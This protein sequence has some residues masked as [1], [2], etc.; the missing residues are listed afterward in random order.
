MGVTVTSE[1]RLYIT[2]KALSGVY[3]ATYFRFQKFTITDGVDEASYTSNGG[4]LIIGRQWI[5]TSGFALA[6]FM[7]AGM[8][9]GNVEL[10]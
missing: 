5:W 2:G 7:G 10:K 8:T 4:G 6:F 1:T 9:E 3:L